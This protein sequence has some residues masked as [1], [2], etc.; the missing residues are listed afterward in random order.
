M[1]PRRFVL[2]GGLAMLT[3][4]SFAQQ[5]VSIPDLERLIFELTNQERTNKGLSELAYDVELA[6]I[7][8]EHS[9]DMI[10]RNFFAH[11]NPREESPTDRAIRNGYNVLKPF[12]GGNNYGVAE[13]IAIMPGGIE[14]VGRGFIEA[15]PEAIARNTVQ[16][17]MKSQGHRENILNP[18]YTNYGTGCTYDG[19]YKYY[20]TQLFF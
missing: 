3:T 17:W 2:I 11:N 16:S 20:S 14:V 18:Q 12:E 7:A 10:D 19:K 6:R 13:N 8:R 9:Q 1:I 5:N 15:T 4:P